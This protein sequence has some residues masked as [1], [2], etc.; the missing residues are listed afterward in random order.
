MYTVLYP[1]NNYSSL[2]FKLVFSWQPQLIAWMWKPCDQLIYDKS[3]GIGIPLLLVVPLLKAVVI[4]FKFTTPYI[5][6]MHKAIFRTARFHTPCI[7]AFVY[8]VQIVF[9]G[10]SIRRQHNNICKYWHLKGLRNDSS[11]D[12]DSTPCFDQLLC[13]RIDN[14]LNKKVKRG[15]PYLA[16]L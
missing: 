11:F 10:F 12:I 13:Q 3:L 8:N 5:V 6:C 16:P 15:H 2:G 9:P 7:E 1:I 14:I 4:S